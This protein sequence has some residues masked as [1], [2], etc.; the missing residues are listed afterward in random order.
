MPLGH[1]G[2]STAAPGQGPP[3][4]GDSRSSTRILLG[5]SQFYEDLQCFT[6]RRRSAADHV[7]HPPG[8]TLR[9]LLCCACVNSDVK[10][11]SVSVAVAEAALCLA[12]CCSLSSAGSRRPRPLSR[13]GQGV[14]PAGRG[15]ESGLRD[16]TCRGPLSAPPH[17]VLPPRPPLTP[18]G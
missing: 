1:A 7:V 3:T 14:K 17:R 16:P 4:R 10:R 18:P 9:W 6:A 12:P 11:T 8:H 13:A 5:V 15:A 2:Q